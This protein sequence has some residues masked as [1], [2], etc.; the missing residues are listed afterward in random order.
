MGW[1]ESAVGL[2]GDT[3]ADA[4]GGAL[5]GIAEQETERPTTALLIGSFIAALNLDGQQEQFFRGS[6]QVREIRLSGERGVV[7]FSP[8]SARDDLV[9][10]FYAAVDEASEAYRED[11]DRPPSVLELLQY[12]AIYLEGGGEENPAAVCDPA[13]WEL[14][15]AKVVLSER[16]KHADRLELPARAGAAAEGPRDVVRHAKFGVGVVV[17][18]QES[19]ALVRFE[20]GTERLIQSAFLTAV[21]ER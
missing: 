19:A 16:K 18:Y 4:I 12:F 7:R 1:F 9:T 6:R 11:L 17:R 15:E 2:N 8:K 13:K 21:R 14:A 3:P 5:S 20:D 10:T